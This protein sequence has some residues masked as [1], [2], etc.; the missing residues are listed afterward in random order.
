[1]AAMEAQE[2]SAHMDTTVLMKQLVRQMK[3]LNFWIT[4]FGT[5]MLTALVITGLLVWQL[6]SFVNTTNQRLD[7]IRATTLDSLNVSKKT[8]DS[9]GELGSWLRDHTGLCS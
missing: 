9:S 6:V 1:M 2:R 3:I 8:C 7:N 4:V 5:L